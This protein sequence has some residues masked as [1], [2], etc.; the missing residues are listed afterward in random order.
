M[1]CVM[2]KRKNAPKV[3]KSYF[4]FLKDLFNFIS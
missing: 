1:C 3:R 4:L 2:K